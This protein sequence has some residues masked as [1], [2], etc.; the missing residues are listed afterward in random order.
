M[1][2]KD[3]SKSEKALKVFDPDPNTG[4]SR[5]VTKREMVERYPELDHSN[6][7]DWGRY[8]AP[9]AKKFILVRFPEQGPIEGYQLRGFR[10]DQG[11]SKYIRK[12]I[13]DRVVSLQCPVTGVST[14]AAG[15]RIECDHKNGRYDDLSLQEPKTQTV[16]E[17]QPLHKNVNT[18]KRE[19]CKRCKEF[20]KRFDAKVLGFTVSWLSG[21]MDYRKD[22]GGC[23]GCYWHDVRL[24]HASLRLIEANTPYGDR[25]EG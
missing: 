24:F 19:H 22:E 21:G 12:D 16:A 5:V 20:G 8:D 15:G 25:S 14:N 4:I 17:F 9:L 3:L 18:I 1:P 11:V 23:V 2:P 10:T 13:R 7:W 6:G